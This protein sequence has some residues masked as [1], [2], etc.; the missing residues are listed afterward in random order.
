M[1]VS[2][3]VDNIKA[4]KL[5]SRLSGPELNIATS[6]ALN[7]AG[8]EARKVIQASLDTS[9]DRVTPYIKRSIQVDR[10]TPDNLVATVEPKYMGGKGVDPQNILQASVFGGQRKH[11]ASERAFAR[12]GILQPGY[13]IVPGKQCPLDRYGNIKGSFMVQLI[14]YFQAFGEQGYKANMTAKRK[15]KLANVG[16]TATGFKAINGVAYFLSHGKLRS[17]R[18][19]SHLPYGIWSK[20]GTHGADVKPIIM[21][22]KRPSYRA[23]LD[24]FGKPVRAAIDKFNPRLRY[25]MRTILEAKA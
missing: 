12:V 8:F 13:S 22:V 9:F 6:K 11:K 15:A 25:H 7:D 10:A 3:H 18:G 5:I 2:M 23:R 16:R 19:G 24:F 1:K 21:F 20:T 4:L 14:S 17:G